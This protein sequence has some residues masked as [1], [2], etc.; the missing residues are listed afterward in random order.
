MKVHANHPQEEKHR[1]QRIKH[2][3]DGHCVKHQVLNPS[4]PYK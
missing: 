2:Q 3:S 4:R 1:A